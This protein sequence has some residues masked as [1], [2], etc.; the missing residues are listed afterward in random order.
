MKSRPIIFVIAASVSISACSTLWGDSGAKYRATS[1]WMIEQERGW[2]DLA[3]GGRWV[4]SE[5]LAD[6]FRG[7]LPNGRRYGKPPGQP[8]Y[9]QSTK[10][11]TDCSLDEASVRFFGSRTAVVFGRE[12]KTVTLPDGKHERRCLV[13][14]DSWLQRNGKWQIIAAQDNRIECPSPD[15][16]P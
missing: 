9:D 12:S 10:W 5:V 16:H 15:G 3:C 2:A 7:T 6:D 14:T 1:Q 4:A 11:S 13:W 8:T